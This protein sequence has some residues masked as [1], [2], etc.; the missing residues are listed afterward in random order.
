MFRQHPLLTVVTL[1]YLGVVGLLTLGPQ[2]FDESSD[3]IVWALL[4]FFARH[5]QTAWIDYWTLQFGANVLM[6]IPV[7]LFFLLLLGRRRW[8]VAVLIGVLLTCAIE[9]TQRFLPDRVSDWR[10][11]LANSV[12]AFVGVIL[13]LILTWRPRAG[14]VAPA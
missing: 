8:W 11:I 5:R 9:F 7:G 2:P 6:F 13:A 3:S 14:R 1:L 10:D 12:G 4:R